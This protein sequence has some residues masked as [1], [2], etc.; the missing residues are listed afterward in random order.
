MPTDT[1]ALTS[2]SNPRLLEAQNDLE[3]L[4]KRSL[5]QLM[6]ATITFPMSA[7]HTHINES[8]VCKVSMSHTLVIS[9]H[10]FA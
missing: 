5:L 10:L 2:H 8:V 4:F 7:R 3:W 1:L 9:L 6:N